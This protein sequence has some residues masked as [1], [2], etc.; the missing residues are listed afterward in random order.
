MT[1]VEQVATPSITVRRT[2]GQQTRTDAASATGTAR[3]RRRP[4]S[5]TPTPATRHCATSPSP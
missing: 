2:P 1:H 5:T 3:R 4:G